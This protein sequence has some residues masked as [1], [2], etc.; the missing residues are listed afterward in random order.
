MQHSI[1]PCQRQPMQATEQSV[2]SVTSSVCVCQLMCVHA[3]K[4]KWCE[5]PTPNLVHIVNGS[6]SACVDSEVKRSKVKVTCSA[7]MGLQVDTATQVYQLYLRPRQW[8]EVLYFTP[9]VSFFFSFFSFAA[10]SPRWLYRQGTFLA[11]MVGYRCNFKN[12]VE[13]LGS[14]PSLKFGGPKPQC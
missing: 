12:W 7:S 4:G 1:I 2:A 6:C 10:G 14:D 3:L 8:P 11:Q 5:L 9:E 13:N